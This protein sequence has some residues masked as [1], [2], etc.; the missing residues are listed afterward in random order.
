MIL[1]GEVLATGSVGL[2]HIKGNSIHGRGYLLEEKYVYFVVKS[3]AESGV[4]G[5]ACRS[6]TKRR[7]RCGWR[8]I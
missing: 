1:D 5:E 3:L 2:I 4:M 8:T 6:W 7:N